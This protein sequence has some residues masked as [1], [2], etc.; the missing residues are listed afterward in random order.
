MKKIVYL[1]SIIFVLVVCFLVVFW[2]QVV[3]VNTKQYYQ[4]QNITD[5]NFDSYVENNPETKVYFFCQENS[6]NC[7]YVNNVLF[8]A[9]A[10]NLIVDS[11]DFLYYVDLS[12]IDTISYAKAERQWGITNI[13]AFAIISGKAD[14][15]YTLKS[16]LSWDESKPLTFDDLKKWLIDNGQWPN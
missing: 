14:G 3:Q 4:N 11:L 9:I 8:K 16:S 10:K 5:L 13:P 2:P 12:N 1:V 6:N 15:G 7:E